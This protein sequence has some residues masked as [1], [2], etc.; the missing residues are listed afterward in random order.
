MEEQNKQ[1]KTDTTTNITPHITKKNKRATETD[2]RLKKCNIT[3]K[4]YIRNPEN[5]L[6]Y[7][8]D[9]LDRRINQNDRKKQHLNEEGDI[10]NSSD[11]DCI[12]PLDKYAQGNVLT[13]EELASIRMSDI[14]QTPK[15]EDGKPAAQP[16]N[17]NSYLSPEPN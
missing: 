9:A 8:G 14:H 10:V 1:D 16:E 6:Y 7:E 13:E 2:E 12:Q 17:K 4:K 15:K 3:Q 5:I 11:D